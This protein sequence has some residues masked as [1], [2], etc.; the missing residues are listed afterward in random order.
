MVRFFT[1]TKGTFKGHFLDSLFTKTYVDDYIRRFCKLFGFHS[2][3]S[4]FLE[5]ALKGQWHKISKITFPVNIVF[6]K[7]AVLEPATEPAV[8]TMFYKDVIE[9]FY[10]VA[11]SSCRR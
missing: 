9:L 11:S 4:I 10:E 5:T 3:S 7:V 1:F 6:I 8:I 2:Y